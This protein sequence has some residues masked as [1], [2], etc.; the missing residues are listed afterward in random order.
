MCKAFSTT[1]KGSAR[2]GFRK[3]PPGM[4][5]SF[6][7]LSR[8]FVANFMSCRIRQKNASHLFT[9]HQ[10]ETERL[11]DYVKWFNQAILE[12]DDPSDKVV[13]M[14]MME[15]FR[16][17]PLF[18][19]LSKNVPETLSALQNK[20]DKYIIAEELAE[21]KHRRRSK[22]NS[23]RKEPDSRRPDYSN[24]ARNKRSNRDSKLIERRPHTPPR[25]PGLILPP[26]NA[27][28]V[29]VLTEIKHE[30]FVKWPGKIKIDPTR[31]NRNKYC[32][33]HRDHGHNTEDC[34]QLKEQIADLIKKG[35][36]RK[37][38]ANLQ[39]PE[40]IYGNN[41]PTAGDI[42]VIHGGLNPV[43]VQVRLEKDM[44]EKLW[45]GRGGSLQPIFANRRG[46]PANHLQQRRSE[47]FALAP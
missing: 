13:I 42:Q 7:D 25:R 1:L 39:T 15:G 43:D 9:I 33:F 28:I 34:F 36:L 31:R 5:D 4:I 23:K 24:E 32:E 8:L 29:Q 6:G 41:R 17:G 45:T 16:P 26:L 20:A 2:S 12:V 30:E 40:Q 19:S 3:L 37:Y 10:K 44:S 18:D 46:S 22:D 14:A 35:F 47:R 11:K 21:A 27:P 38:V